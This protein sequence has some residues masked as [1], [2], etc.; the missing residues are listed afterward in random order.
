[1]V[2]DIRAAAGSWLS[3]TNLES[4]APGLMSLGT[5]KP[6]GKKILALAEAKGG[7]TF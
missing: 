7:L 1:M 2:V 4:K 5:G 6:F 3:T